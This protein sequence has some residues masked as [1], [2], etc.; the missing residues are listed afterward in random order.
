MPRVWQESAAEELALALA[1]SRAAAD[2][3]LGVAA[4]LAV[5][6]PGTAAALRCGQITDARAVIIAHAA[7]VLDPA[8]AR[9][10]EALVLGRAGRLTPGGLRA[11]IARAVLQVAPGAA[12]RRRETPAR[13]ARVQ[14]WREDSG[15]AAL[16]GHELPPADVLAA[17]E[18]ITWW[19]RQL[20]TAGLDGSTGEL[21]ARAYLDLL[22]DTDSRPARPE[23]TPGPEP[24]DV[25]GPEPGRTKGAAQGDPS[26]HVS[27]RTKGAEPCGKKERERDRNQERA[28]DQKRERG[29]R[30]QGPGQK[31]G[32]APGEL[33]T[34]CRAGSRR[35]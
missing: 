25:P 12:R 18:R 13:D 19:A 14:R 33:R 35:G 23:P 28:A 27:G 9:A 32:R 8:Q 15:N 22:L 24:G 21:R 17:D 20:R 1:Q 5:K 30:G 16:A 26:G 11:A 3:L 4:D 10:A 2:G 29:T 34:G 6:L 7:S 31:P